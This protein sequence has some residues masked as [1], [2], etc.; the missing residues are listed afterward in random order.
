MKEEKVV[1]SQPV[2]DKRAEV[3]GFAFLDSFEAF[4]N[5]CLIDSRLIHISKARHVAPELMLIRGKS[6][7]RSFDFAQD[8]GAV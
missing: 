2:S 1:P 7:C 3:D 8:D 4:D 6:N 5:D